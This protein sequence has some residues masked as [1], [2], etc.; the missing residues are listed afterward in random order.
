M[1]YSSPRKA[2]Q[3][4]HGNS[5]TGPALEFHLAKTPN[6][7]GARP[8]A[9][10][11]FPVGQQCKAAKPAARTITNTVS[12]TPALSTATARDIRATR[13]PGGS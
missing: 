7:P 4:T 3:K 5:V 10:R 8:Q 9:P 2:N 13:R 12:P 6:Q 1:G 11:L